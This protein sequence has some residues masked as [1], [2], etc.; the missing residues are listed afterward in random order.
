MKLK[1]LFRIGLL[2]AVV[3]LT[4]C[5]AFQLRDANEQLTSY[6]G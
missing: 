4:A 1:A 6:Y 2:I 3:G 5:T